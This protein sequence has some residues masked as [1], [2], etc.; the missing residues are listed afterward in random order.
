MNEQVK[1]ARALLS[2]DNDF[3][4]NEIIELIR[5]TTDEYE[6][7]LEGKRIFLF[8]QVIGDLKQEL[9]EDEFEWMDE[10]EWNIRD[11]D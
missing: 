9:E 3:K 5:E 6:S 1:L 4:E 8:R 2:S 11:I 10:S 7:D